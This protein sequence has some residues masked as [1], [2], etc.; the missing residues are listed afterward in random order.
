MRN[1]GDAMRYR[2]AIILAATMAAGFGLAACSGSP[3]DTTTTATP[4]S[5][6]PTT[7]AAGSTVDEFVLEVWNAA[8]PETQVDYCKTPSGW[9]RD[10]ALQMSAT[11][12]VGATTLDN[13]DDWGFE[14]RVASAE[15]LLDAKC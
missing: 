3:A 14:E 13:V 8:G 4:G 7:S 10:S 9:D 11:L 12:M 15:Q 6:Q 5:V 2:V 1:R